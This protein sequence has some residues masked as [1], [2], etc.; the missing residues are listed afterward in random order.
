M[1]LDAFIGSGKLML[2]AM[3]V[4]AVGSVDGPLCA[5]PELWMAIWNAYQ[6]GDLAAAKQAQERATAFHT[7]QWRNSAISAVSWPWSVSA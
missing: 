7:A 3:T 4:G 2:P 6:A 5:A 1:G